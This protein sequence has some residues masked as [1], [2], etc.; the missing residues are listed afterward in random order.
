MLAAEAEDA[1]SAQDTTPA[2]TTK[3][4]ARP[5]NATRNRETM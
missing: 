5:G 1:Q 4:K 3:R 2:M